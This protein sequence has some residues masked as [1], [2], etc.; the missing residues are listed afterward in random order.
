M[1][2]LYVQILNVLCEITEVKVGMGVGLGL[3]C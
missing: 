1:I 2:L 3:R